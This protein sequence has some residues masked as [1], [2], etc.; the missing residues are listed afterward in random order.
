[1]LRIKYLLVAVLI[2]SCS[3]L[4]Q[5]LWTTQI[6]I[7]FII[8]SNTKVTSFADA[9]GMHIA[10]SRNG[11]I[12]YALVNSQGGVIKYDKL[13]EAE[14]SGTNFANV[15]AIGNDIYVFYYKN[16]F[17]QIAKSTNLGDS[18]NNTFDNRQMTNYGCDTL[19]GY[20]VGQEIHIVWT[21]TRVNGYQPESHYIK[22]VPDA[23]TKWQEYYKVT[24]VEPEGGNNPDVAISIDKVHVDYIPPYPM[25][26]KSRTRLSNG[27]WETPQAVP[28]Y[29]LPYT[30][31]KKVKPIITGSLLN[32][33][34]RA[35]FGT[36]G[37]S[38]SYIGHS[39]RSLSS[40]TWAENPNV[41]LVLQ[42]NL[43][44]G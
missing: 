21:E 29:L 14:G 38:G 31:T 27:T 18:W 44:L 17:I 42:A 7:D 4:A 15:V 36:I 30:V 11:G 12:R 10:Y 39:Y 24:D 5:N 26:P 20:L 25:N 33:I 40:S 35:N 28:F 6:Q 41:I 32:E 9:N 34:Y 43:I 23:L 13:I 22:F 19:V 1:M 2:L 37:V 16:N 8:Q 3:I